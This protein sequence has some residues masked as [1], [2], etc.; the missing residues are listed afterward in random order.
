MHVRKKKK[1][2]A[3]KNFKIGE[4]NL[5]VFLLT[6]KQISEVSRNEHHPTT[7]IYSCFPICLHYN[8]TQKDPIKI[9]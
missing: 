1:V 9:H 5:V 7:L 8:Y 4:Q 2:Y 6:T 3:G